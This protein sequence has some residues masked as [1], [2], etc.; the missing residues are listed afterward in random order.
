MQ[1]NNLKLLAFLLLSGNLG[2]CA[3]PHTPL[4][5]L[6]GNA[7]PPQ[8]G[9]AKLWQATR[10]YSGQRIPATLEAK[11]RITFLP[12][13]QLIHDRTDLLVDIYDPSGNPSRKNIRFFYENLDVTQAMMLQAKNIYKPDQSHL[14]LQVKNFRLP[15]DKEHAIYVYYLPNNTK[16]WIYSRYL[17]PSCSAFQQDSVSDIGDFSV[18]DNL[19]TTINQVALEAGFN[20]SYYAGLIAQESSFDIRAVSS[21][22]AIGLTQITSLAEHT[23]LEKYPQWPH[24]DVVKTEN[25]LWIRNAI[26]SGKIHSKNEWRLDPQRSIIGGVTYLNYLVRYWSMPHNKEKLERIFPDNKDE[27]LA[28]LLLASY[29]SGAARVNY[30][31]DQY[32]KNWIKAPFLGEARKYVHRIFSFCYHFADESSKEETNDKT[33]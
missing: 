5:A 24:N 19:L 12:T 3:G 33:S 26:R 2:G 27:A 25:Y 8:P 21:A 17:P 15:S 31:L 18:P 29:N 7:K 28:K 9:N 22:K 1:K 11:P 23:I 20:P 14:R 6:W 16:N 13:R 4:G 30:A 10:S 32:G